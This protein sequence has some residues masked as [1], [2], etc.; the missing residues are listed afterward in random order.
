MNKNSVTIIDNKNNKK[1]NYPI[2]EGKRGPDVVDMRSFFKDSGMFTYDPGFTSTASC[3]SQITFINGLE[4]E[5]RYRGIKIDE[6]A[7]K[8]SYLEVCYLLLN[9]KLPNKD[10]LENYDKELRHRAFYTEA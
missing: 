8:H 7:T 2:L 4:G 10:E 5:L 1:Y 6:L 3:K 9:S